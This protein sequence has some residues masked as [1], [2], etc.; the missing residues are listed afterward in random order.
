MTILEFCEWIE[1]TAFGAIARESLYG[2]QI[3]VG[4]H[5]LGITLSVGT[6]L[7]ADLR[8]LGLVMRRYSVSR[9]YRALAP[10][11]LSGF[12][13]M[14][15][16]GFM[17]FA[18]FATSAY[19]NL[20][21]RIKLAAIALAGANAL[22]FHFVIQRRIAAWDEAPRPPAAVRVSGL[23]SVVLWATVVLAGRMISYTLF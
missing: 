21:F 14:F 22:I 5:I 8:M 2:F 17:L 19:D 4:I 1:T 18:G 9:V 6:L 7:W 16:S 23:A 12:A 15:A 20:Y 13:V 3:L 10:W 11:F